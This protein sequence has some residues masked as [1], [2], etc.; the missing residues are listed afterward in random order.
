MIVAFSSSSPACSV[1]LFDD[2][3]RLLDGDQAE[4]NQNASAKLLELLDALL[5]KRGAILNDA[6]GFLADIGPGSF[7]GTRVA[8]MLAKVMAYGRAV[9]VAGG[10]SLDLI[11]G[12]CAIPNRKGE[13][14]LRRGT[15]DPPELVTELPPDCR[16]YGAA[17]GEQTYPLASGFGAIWDRLSYTDAFTFV[18]D[19]LVAPSISTPKKQLKGVH[20]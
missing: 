3:G 8:V 2:S 9:P 15:G 4:A 20:G 10:S 19:Y 12:M 7:T 1:A 13:W 6:T 16:G 5:K 18:P 11:G 14:F 17:F